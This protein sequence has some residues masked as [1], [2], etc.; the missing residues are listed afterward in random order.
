MDKYKLRGSRFHRPSSPAAASF[1]YPRACCLLES[2][3]QQKN[4]GRYGGGEWI[5]VLYFNDLHDVHSGGGTVPRWIYRP[6]PGNAESSEGHSHAFADVVIENHRLGLPVIL[7]LNG[8]M[9]ET[10]AETLL[11]RAQRFL[12]TNGEPR[13]GPG[14]PVVQLLKHDCGFSGCL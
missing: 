2:R 12:E 9:M 11:P 6:C 13:P 14:D 10:P 7:Y 4:A 1:G 5:S 8:E 3:L